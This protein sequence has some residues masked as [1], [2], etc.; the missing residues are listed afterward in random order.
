MGSYKNPSSV[1]WAPTGQAG[2]KDCVGGRLIK[3]A[4]GERSLK[5]PGLAGEEGVASG[6]M[7]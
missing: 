1:S 3:A 2:Q 7:A 4:P 6:Q 5:E